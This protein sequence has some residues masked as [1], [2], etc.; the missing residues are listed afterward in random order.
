ML[1]SMRILHG[2]CYEEESLTG[3]VCPDEMCPKRPPSE[4]LVWHLQEVRSRNGSYAKGEV[5]VEK[6]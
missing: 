3:R 4:V 2:E 6:Q 1:Y 5:R